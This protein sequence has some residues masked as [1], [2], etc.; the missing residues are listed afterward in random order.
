MYDNDLWKRSNKNKGNRILLLEEMLFTAKLMYSINSITLTTLS[1]LKHRIM[2]K[3]HMKNLYKTPKN[4]QIK[5]SSRVE[6]DHIFFTEIDGRERPSETKTSTLF[7]DNSLH[8]DLEN[9]MQKMK[10]FNS[11][12]L[13][14][15]QK[16]VFLFPMLTPKQ[17]LE[18]T[19]RDHEYF[20]SFH[21]FPN[22]NPDVPMQEMMKSNS[23][24]KFEHWNGMRT[25][26][27]IPSDDYPVC[28]DDGFF[29]LPLCD[30]QMF[31]SLYEFTD[32]EID[33]DI[34]NFCPLVFNKDDLDFT[35]KVLTKQQIRRYIHSQIALDV[36]RQYNPIPSDFEFLYLYNFKQFPNRL[37]M[38]KE[39][40]DRVIFM[41]QKYAEECSL[42]KYIDFDPL[43]Q[44]Q[45]FHFQTESMH[46]FEFISD[47]D[48]MYTLH[49]DSHCW[50]C[51]YLFYM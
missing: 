14:M 26:F 28:L 10:D 35:S 9:L 40:G 5:F 46:V 20:K 24:S 44:C 51:W 34:I 16:F 23:K 47:G 41:D 45:T 36:F 13:E 3:E 19:T 22:I 48:N 15:D 29:I 12:K 49:C 31:D 43:T 18:A 32:I 25:T 33:G 38:P 8:D 50:Y 2:T 6:L 17:A 39:K 30:L 21:C 42:P 37:A 4:P 11:V 27:S 1:V 7:L